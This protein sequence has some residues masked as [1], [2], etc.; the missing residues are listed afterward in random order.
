MSRCSGALTPLIVLR[1]AL[2]RRRASLLQHARSTCL[3]IQPLLSALALGRLSRR[4][5]SQRFA[6]GG[7]SGQLRLQLRPLLR[8]DLLRS[9]DGL[10]MSSLHFAS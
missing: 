5:L 7:A 2:L 10:L 4:R 1:L 3:G 8:Y 6:L 9:S